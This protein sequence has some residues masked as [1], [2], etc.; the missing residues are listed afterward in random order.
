MR[1]V[2]MQPG[3]A[4]AQDFANFQLWRS[5]LEFDSEL[6]DKWPRSRVNWYAVLGFAVTLG[7]SAAFWTGVGVLVAQIWK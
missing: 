2:V 5:W 7:V 1:V 6:D 4:S 3:S